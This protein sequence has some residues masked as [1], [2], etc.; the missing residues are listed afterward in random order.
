[1]PSGGRSRGDPVVGTLNAWVLK[2]SATEGDVRPGDWVTTTASPTVLTEDS[3]T[4][5]E[6]PA[7]IDLVAGD[8]LGPLL[9]VSGIYR[10]ET[11]RGWVLAGAVRRLGASGQVVEEPLGRVLVPLTSPVTVATK[12]SRFW[13]VRRLA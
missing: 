3:R 11:V 9:R 2:A 10:R 7:G 8:K 4:L 1:M 12:D 13:H 5:A 6:L